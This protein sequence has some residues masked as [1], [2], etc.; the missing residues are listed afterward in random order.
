MAID[1]GETIRSSR[2][3]LA[4]N[5][6]I[7]VR[8]GVD[9]GADFRSGSVVVEED[10]VLREATANETANYST[11]NTLDASEVDLRTKAGVANGDAGPVSVTGI[12]N[13]LKAKFPEDFE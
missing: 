5:S 1:S 8:V 11:A 9:D 4:D 10:G 3:R 13:Y 12:L 7:L 6:V 2:V